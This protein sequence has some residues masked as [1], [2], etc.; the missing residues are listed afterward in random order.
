MTALAAPSLLG[1][2]E[3]RIKSCPS[4]AV[5]LGDEA[6][7]FAAQAGL[8]L[9]PWQQMVLRESMGMAPGGKWAAPQVGLL[10]PRQNGKGSVLEAR[11][12]FGLFVLGEELI[13]HSAHK[14][15]TSQEHFLRMR[16]L[17]D[18]NDDLSRHVKSVLTANGKESI[19]LRNGNRLK[20]KART[21]SGSGR[22][23]SGDL[24]VLDEAML[25]PEQA[26]DAMLPTLITRKNPQTWFTSSAGT[27]DSAALWRI[28]KRGRAQAPRL[29]YFEWGCTP[30][31]DVTDRANWAAANPGF[32]YRIPVEALEDDIEQMSADG[33]AREHLGVWDDAADVDG[34][35]YPAWCALADPDAE[36]G[37]GA[38]FGV[39]TAPDRAWSAIAVAWRRPD[40]HV[41]TMMAD[42]RRGATWV[43]DRVTELREKWGGTVLVD[44]AA[45]GLIPGAEEV[46]LSHQAVAHNALAD[47]IEAGKIRHGNNTSLNIAVKAAVWRQSGDTRVLDR[48]SGTD[49]S[50]VVAAALAYHAASTTN[51]DITLSIW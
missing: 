24:L 15:D 49:I 38:V 22:G 18:G 21:I 34:L 13:I 50:P 29:A 4:Y 31:V 11:E 10:V 37:A 41:Q 6:V 23:F 12:L 9:D 3:P 27:P 14:F 26:L 1:S 19:T 28:V 5:S 51:S 30:G 45:R 8:Y 16:N 20:F 48:R 7:D 2:Q 25:L 40:G 43:P 42:F 36:R 35:D 39:A 47:A 32:G 44:T 46:S 17:I 33:F